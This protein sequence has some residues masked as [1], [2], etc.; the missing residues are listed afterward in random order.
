[1][2]DGQT[3]QVL[4]RWQTSAPAVATVSFDGVVSA[5][6]AGDVT[7]SA[8]HQTH[9]AEQNVR[10]LPDYAGDWIGAYRVTN[11]SDRGDWD[12]LC[13]DEDAEDVWLLELTFEQ[14]DADVR[15][16]V[17]A[18]AELP[19]PVAGSIGA[20]GRLGVSG[21]TE[22]EEDDVE[23]DLDVLNWDSVTTNNR[24]MSGTF[25]LVLSSPEVRGDMRLTC[26]IVRMNK[27]APGSSGGLLS[28]P[29]RMRTAA[30]TARRSQP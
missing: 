15:G 11:C 22:Y 6:G 4:G 29:A 9:R 17:G 2:S 16:S 23:F 28:V 13:D 1:M 19:V 30:A 8:E 25:V 5:I 14:T 20:T 24:A 26:E 12:G 27:A 18:Y 10:V 3:G 7:I 21:N